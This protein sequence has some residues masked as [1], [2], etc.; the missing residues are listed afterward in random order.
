MNRW[1]VAFGRFL[2]KDEGQ[3]LVEYGLIIAL[4]AVVVIG[5]LSSMGGG[6]QGL[7]GG[8]TNS[9]SNHAG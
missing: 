3:S 9:I 1:L 5:V 7:F 4:V 6:L 2:R 8:V